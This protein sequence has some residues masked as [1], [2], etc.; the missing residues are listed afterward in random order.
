LIN[1]QTATPSTTAIT[2]S[3]AHSKPIGPAFALGISKE[4]ISEKWCGKALHPALM[5]HVKENW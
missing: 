1:I 5:S 2:P 4:K 3:N